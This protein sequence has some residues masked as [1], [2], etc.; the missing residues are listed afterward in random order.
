MVVLNRFLPFIRFQTLIEAL[1]YITTGALP[2]GKLAS[3]VHSVEASSK[4]RVDGLVKLQFEDC[5]GR[6]C[7]ATKRV[8]AALT[9]GGKLQCKSDEF[10]IQVTAADGQIKSLSSKVADF[11]K[12]IV[13]LLGVPAAILDNVIFC[14]QEESVWPLSEPKELK[15][16]FDRIFQLT[17]F[18]KALE[19]MKK[20][21]RDYEGE[22]AAL[23]EKQSCKEMVV[24]SKAK[25]TQQRDSNE[26]L[27]KESKEKIQALEKK[28]NECNAVITNANQQLQKYEA[29]ERKAEVKRAELHMLNDQ[30]T[31]IRVAPYPGSESELRAEI[32]EMDSSSEFRELEAQRDRLK[33]KIESISN[34]ILKLKME[35]DEAECQ[36][37]KLMS[38]EMVRRNLE[39]EME[40]AERKLSTI[41][42]LS[43][44]DYVA[45]LQKMIECEE[46]ELKE[47][48]ESSAA[49]R[50][51]RQ[52][53]LEVA[54]M[55]CSKLDYELNSSS[56]A[57]E[58]LTREIK[59][60]EQKLKDATVSSNEAAELS[61]KIN[62]LETRMSE[63]P[64][65]D[66]R[67][68]ESLRKQ[69]QNLQKEVEV[70]RQC[71]SDAM[72]S[73]ETEREVQRKNSKREELERELEDLMQKHNDA[74]VSTFGECPSGPWSASVNDLVRS[75]EESNQQTENE[76]RKSERDLDRAS[77]GLEQ[78][79]AEEEK[80]IG[81][82]EQLRKKI[83]DLCGCSSQDVAENLS[84]TRH[85]LTKLRK[86][87]SSLSTKAMLYETWSEETKTRSCCPLCERKFSSK[88]G[89]NELSG[90]LLDMSL[91]M[92]DDIE[93][94]E[95]QVAESEEKERRLA[96]AVVYVDQCKK[97]ME[98]KVRHVRKQI[99]TYRKEEALLNTKVEQLKEDMETAV[100]A[101]KQLLE[102][103]VEPFDHVLIAHLT[104]NF[105][106]GRMYL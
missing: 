9:K 66:E 1:N 57:I 2:A 85:L 60:V 59:N 3:F 98:E 54:Q 24:K 86:E 89:V 64:N 91:S 16:R 21:K 100:I 74:F 46:S 94:L 17:R 27:R 82:V 67:R 90:K 96:S 20:M 95:K 14:H 105:Y 78:T 23:V 13:N 44:K 97:I 76:L 102:I 53:R 77:Q 42:G 34:D 62:A 47:L 81:E 49:L 33:T 32:S 103:K 56:T 38:Y 48:K 75:R 5:K 68:S 22:L 51:E 69:R 84:E 87:L 92:P 50:E 41:Y 26:L 88:A 55:E 79:R 80:L 8:N 104:L 18:V 61:E 39:V 15:L 83:V 10:N 101:H 99:A 7:V 6:T 37:R 36:M 12:E 71:C 31:R 93:R 72:E 52:A 19:V 40:E 65:V 43:G 28:I 25:Y 29:V 30:L 58:S 45:E 35:K 63:I 11:Q 73:E 106:F 4:P 70:L